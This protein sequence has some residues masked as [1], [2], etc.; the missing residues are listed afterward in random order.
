[1]AK[2]RKKNNSNYSS[3]NKHKNENKVLKPP[4]N[5]L[6][7]Q[8][9]FSSW[10]NDRMPHMLWACILAGNLERERY[11]HLFRM[12]ARNIREEF[13]HYKSLGI[14][15]ADFVK[16][17][18]AEFDCA[19]QQVFDDAKAVEALRCLLFVE[20]LPDL[21]HWKRRLISPPADGD[22]RALASGVLNCFDHQSQ[23]ATDVRWLK[24]IFLMITGKM[25][26][27]ESMRDRVEEFRLYPDYGDMRK[28]RPSIRS[29]EMMLNGSDETGKIDPDYRKISDDFWNHMLIN[30]ECD[31]AQRFKPPAMPV[32]SIRSE[33]YD[34]AKF[35]SEHFD[36]TLTTTKLDARHDVSFG[37]VL[38]AAALALE[39]TLGY[40]HKMAGGRILLRSIMEAYI[41]LHYLTKKDDAKE[42]LAYRDDGAGKTK[43]AFL[44]NLEAE[45]K[46]DFIDIDRLENLANEDMWLEFRDV[47][48][49]AWSKKDLRKLAIECG[50]K[51]TYDKYYDWASGY[52][53]GQWVCIRDTAFSV[54]SNPLHRFHKI[55]VPLKTAMPSVLPDSCKL[56]NM[57]L[58]DINSLYPS[59]KVRLRSYKLNEVVEKDETEEIDKFV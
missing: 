54:C 44:K 18:E 29:A 28:V 13:P 38:Y 6:P 12:V 52:A 50:A 41:T 16:F 23:N 57:M 19:F 1:M 7:G 27:P 47:N 3:I 37:L 46:P 30:T 48:I 35:I 40:G 36:A 51:E 5:T 22:A 4:M 53:H 31:I 17:S 33:M 42:W 14:S 2:K 21:A 20:C 39:L 25:I 43:L 15:H 32:Q 58:D 59:F 49:G 34:L 45:E 56:I 26:F 11:L 24:V 9:N 55:P 10:V 8:V